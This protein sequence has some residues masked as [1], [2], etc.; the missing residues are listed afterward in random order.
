MS[1]TNVDAVRQ[2]A[3]IL[4]ESE[5]DDDDDDDFVPRT[6]IKILDS[7]TRKT[8]RFG[9]STPDTTLFAPEAVLAAKKIRDEKKRRL[10]ERDSSP[11]VGRMHK[12]SKFE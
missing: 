3:Q 2:R 8:T 1:S 10:R 7:Q 5:G 9:L 12:R 4:D 6:P 11:S